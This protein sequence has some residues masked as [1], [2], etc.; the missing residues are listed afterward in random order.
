MSF[1]A[2]LPREEGWNKYNA[3]QDA[4]LVKYFEYLDGLR[5]SGIVNMFGAGAYIVSAYGVSQ[6]RAQEVLVL[7]MKTFSDEPATD[8]VARLKEGAQAP[9]QS[10]NT[11]GDQNMAKMK[12]PEVAAPAAEAKAA[13]VKKVKEPVIV[14]D[15][16]GKEVF[17]G[18]VGDKKYLFDAGNGE[19]LVELVAG[20]PIADQAQAIARTLIPRSKA[21]KY[22]VNLLF[23]NWRAA[24][25]AKPEIAVATATA[26]A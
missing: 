22:A 2:T 21:S 8:R 16:N 13:R 11:Q 17:E 3:D 1:N 24:R 25:P 12:M 23:R 20:T 9:I 5:E 7:W 14:P 6:S 10:K 18:T 4:I 19:T 15:A 26:T